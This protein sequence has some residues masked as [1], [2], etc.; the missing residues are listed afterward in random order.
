[1]SCSSSKTAGASRTAG[2]QHVIL[3]AHNFP[4]LNSSGCQRPLRFW[5]YLPENGITAH[6]VCSSHGGADPAMAGVHHV[7][8]GAE[9]GLSY[10][11]Q[12]AVAQVAHRIIPHNERIPWVPAAVAAAERIIAGFP[13]SAVISTFPP[14]AGHLA[15][16]WIARRHR[17]KWIADFRDQ[18]VGNPFRGTKGWRHESFF[19]RRIFRQADLLV[20]VTDGFLA[21]WRERFPQY[22]SKMRVLWNGFDPGEEFPQAPLTPRARR[23][24]AHAGAIYGQRHPQL[25]LASLER[26]VETG[27]L[28]PA[29]FVVQLTGPLLEPPEVRPLSSFRRLHEFG[30]LEVHE[31]VSRSEA[32]RRIASADWLLI[33]DVNAFNAPHTVPAKLFDYIRAAR[34]ILGIVPKGSIVERITTRAQVPSVFLYPGDPPEC[35]D[36]KVLEFLSRPPQPFRPADWFWQTFDGRAQAA[37]LAEMVKTL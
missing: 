34:P 20:T 36:R 13:I 1:M 30:C 2:Q 8:S 23:I 9:G 25:L 21:E 26:L 19:E 37:T 3:F 35:V 17:L 22:E 32:N 11:I 15:A 5:K 27:R 28:D 4:P 10:A 33:L 16:A 24:L 14:L 18:L 29:C 12:R 6:V 7:P 31:P